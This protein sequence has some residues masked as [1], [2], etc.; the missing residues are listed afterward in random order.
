MLKPWL[1]FSM[2]CLIFTVYACQE[3]D[4]LTDPVDKP[5]ADTTSTDTIPE[6]DILALNLQLPETPFNYANIQL[7]PFFNIP[8]TP[9]PDNTPANNQ[10]SDWGATLGRALFYDPNLSANNAVACASCHHQENALA[11]P[12]VLSA[13]FEGGHTGRHSMSLTNSRYYPRGQFFWDERAATLEDQTLMPI[14][15]AV[16]MGTKL[17]DLEQ[18]LALIPYYPDLFERAF[19]SPEISSELIARAL[20]QFIRS[21]VSF[22]SKYDEG[23]TQLTPPQNP[24]TTDFPNF[25]ELENLGKQVFFDVN[26]GNCAVCHGTQHFMA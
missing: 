5:D 20:A 18:K 17:E 10:I 14:Q 2:F 19:G 22:S 12:F 4:A 3:D 9:N 8:G 26:R 25:T 21:M 7:P 15:D 24:A 23:F 16:E 1:Y 6:Y 13:G 11:D